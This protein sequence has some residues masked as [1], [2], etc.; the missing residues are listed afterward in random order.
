MSVFGAIYVT[1]FSFAFKSH[2]TNSSC[3]ARKLERNVETNLSWFEA[4]DLQHT[5][6]NWAVMND[7]SEPTEFAIPMGPLCMNNFAFDNYNT[8]MEDSMMDRYST[9]SILG[10][11]FNS[12]K[13][14]SEIHPAERV[15]SKGPESEKTKVKPAL[16]STHVNTGAEFETTS[17]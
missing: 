14:G 10:R 3:R 16:K 11:D 13:R 5:V 7:L 15:F 12:I 17:T 4:F 8:T 6:G 1:K 2:G 9:K